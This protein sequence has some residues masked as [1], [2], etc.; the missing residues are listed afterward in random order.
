MVIITIVLALSCRF[1]AVRRFALVTRVVSD[2]GAKLQRPKHHEGS[3]CHPYR[4]RATIIAVNTTHLR[5]ATQHAATTIKMD[6]MEPDSLGNGASNAIHQLKTEEQLSQRENVCFW[7]DT[8]HARHYPY[9]T[10]RHGRSI[11]CRV[12]LFFSLC[13]AIDALA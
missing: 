12:Y 13:I 10:F 4:H 1:S 6:T 11:V 9:S 7:S 5:H 8:Q 2:C 3:Q